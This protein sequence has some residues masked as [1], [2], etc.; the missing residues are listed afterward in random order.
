MQLLSDLL[1]EE[2]PSTSAAIMRSKFPIK[3]TK[4]EAKN[5]VIHGY[6][7]AD[8]DYVV[9]PVDLI[10]RIKKRL[11]KADEPTTTS[12]FLIVHD[13]LIQF[14]LI[15]RGIARPWSAPPDELG[16]EFT[17][18][19]NLSRS[20]LNDA[21]DKMIVD[22]ANVIIFN[23]K[24]EK[25][26]VNSFKVSVIFDT[27]KYHDIHDAL[28]QSSKKTD[29]AEYGPQNKWTSEAKIKVIDQ[30]AI[31][32]N[33]DITQDKKYKWMCAHFD[34]KEVESKWVFTIPNVGELNVFKNGYIRMYKFARMNSYNP[35]TVVHKPTGDTYDEKIKNSFARAVEYIKRIL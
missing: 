15:R 30:S 1:L 23:V 9:G 20:H 21:I 26:L 7:D 8:T 31:T 12:D 27:T 11:P 4:T 35:A 33:Y 14:A 32:K 18:N 6:E 5:G 25:S 17:Q 28:E 22:N 13:V 2:S 10:K 24:P 19:D 16:T 34:M 3:I 29:S